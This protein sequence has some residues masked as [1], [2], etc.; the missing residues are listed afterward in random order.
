MPEGSLGLIRDN[1]LIVLKVL[2]EVGM[3]DIGLQLGERIEE[4]MSR[5]RGRGLYI[6]ISIKIPN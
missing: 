5:K 6:V 3:G 4:V 2:L 1:N